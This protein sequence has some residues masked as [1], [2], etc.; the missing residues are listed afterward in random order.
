MGNTYVSG[1]FLQIKAIKESFQRK[2]YTSAR[3]LTKGNFEFQYG[4]AEA[5]TS[6]HRGRG[7]WHA[8]WM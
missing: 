7:I 4:Y 3:L 5:R 8:F 2:D 6:V 1:G